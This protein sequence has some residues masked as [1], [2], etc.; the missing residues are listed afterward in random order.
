LEVVDVERFCPLLTPFY[1]RGPGRPA[2]EPVRRLKREFRQYHHIL[3]D[4]QVIERA[5]G[6][7][8]YRFFLGLSLKD[9]THV[10]ADVAVPA[11]LAFLAQTRD[12][13]LAAAEAWTWCE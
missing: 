9:A 7:A 3:S 1:S 4:R 11:T 13:L 6:D 12:K 5:H 2:E 10:I 8:A